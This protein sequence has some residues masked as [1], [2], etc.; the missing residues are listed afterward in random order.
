LL[1]N[2]LTEKSLNAPLAQKSWT[3]RRQ[4]HIIKDLER[5]ILQHDLPIFM[6]AGSLLSLVRDGDFFLSDKDMD[7]GVLGADFERTTQLLI[8]SRYFDDVSPAQYFVG[9][10]QL[11]HRATGFIVDVTHYQVHSE[12][13]HAIWKHVSG[14]V[15]R[16]TSFPLF[17]LKEAFFPSLAC[18]V[19]IPDQPEIY[20]T[21]LYGDW[22]TPNPHFNTVVAACNLCKITPFLLSLSFIKIADDLLNNRFLKAKASVKHLHDQSFQSPLLT[23]IYDLL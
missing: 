10:K 7:V 15:L 21:S 17:E 5:I 13:I 2:S 6:V 4:H 14:E 18:R 1:A 16:Q 3:R 8:D 20:L 9:Y 19:L 11:R 23:H 12:K 22:R